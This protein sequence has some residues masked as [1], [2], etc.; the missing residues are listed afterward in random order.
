MVVVLGVTVAV[1]ESGFKL[2]V[3]TDGVMLTLEAPVK[4]QDIMLDWP[5][6][7]LAGET[8]KEPIVGGVMTEPPPPPPPE[9]AVTA[10]VV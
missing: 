4:L 1:P 5:A 9:R 3:L 2:L 10:T 8:R 6:R 7:M